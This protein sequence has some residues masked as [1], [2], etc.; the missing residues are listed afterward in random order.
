[1]LD[2]GAQFVK[3]GVTVRELIDL[4]TRVR[5]LLRSMHLR[6]L[7]FQAPNFLVQGTDLAGLGL[8]R[9]AHLDLLE[10]LRALAQHVVGDIAQVD[11][12][13]VLAGKAQIIDDDVE[14][15]DQI[16]T[17][18]RSSAPAGPGTARSWEV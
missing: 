1:L 17:R 3:S 7:I 13:A 9:I 15:A 18:R 8:L 11:L 10:L 6:Q 16:R 14:A 12:G 2:L 5:E 4:G